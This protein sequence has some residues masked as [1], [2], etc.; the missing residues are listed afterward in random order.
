MH[1]Q[2]GALDRA[3]THTLALCAIPSPS[4]FS[5][6]AAD[7]VEKSLHALGLS[8]L[9]GRKGSV[10]CALGGE[11]R[12]LVL[13]AHVDTLGAVVR[14]VKPNGR[15]RYS[16]IGSYPD[17]NVVGETCRIHCRD[18]RSFTGTFQPVEASS[19]VN[20]RLKDLK[21]DEDSVE[22]LVDETVASKAETLALGIGPGDIVSIDAR[23]I[24]TPSGYL[25][26]RH[27]DD[28]AACGILLA[29]AEEAADGRLEL[30]RRVSLLFTAYEEV[31][32]GGAVVPAGTEE[33]ISV[34]MGAVGED[35]GCDE[36]S[37]SICSKDSRGPYD[38]DVTTALVEAAGRA[39]CRHAVDVYP[40]YGSDAD[41]ALAAGHDLR[42]GLVGPGVYASH[43]YER[44]HREAIGNTIA[45][46][47]E[48]LKV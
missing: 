23:P 11:G 40:S 15:L 46:L 17:L 44:T 6:A 13:A 26:S 3:V 35:L 24:L 14:A 20:V 4:G 36:R 29:L 10:L 7:Y 12:P 1:D 21:P 39:G 48:Y 8:P 33:F 22:I 47:A 28:K 42:H 31:G 5:S 19:H 32:H 30:G 9:R 34:D 38:W 43:G 2:P 41:V 16:K 37:V 27:L 25:K 18:G 45:L